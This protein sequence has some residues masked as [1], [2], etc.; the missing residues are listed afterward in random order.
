[1]IQRRQTLYLLAIVAVGVVLFFLPVL[2]FTTPETS[3]IQRM[4]LLSAQGLE[5]VTTEL[6]Y[7]ELPA[8]NLKGTWGLT[9]ISLLIP[10]LSLVDIFL[11]RHRL[12][13]A[14]LNIFTAMAC[15][16]YYAM[17]FMYVWFM[18]RV[19]IHVEWNICF[20]SCLPLVCLILVVGATRLILKDEMLVKA[21]DRLR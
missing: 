19:I 6:D 12:L 20:A 8:I 3:T 13:Q 16:G 2:Q 10:F 21:A 7:G 1:M 18:R 9:V 5:E 17:L 4:F 11:Y 15:I 14:R